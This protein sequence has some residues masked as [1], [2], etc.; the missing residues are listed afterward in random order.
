[1]QPGKIISFFTVTLFNF[2]LEYGGYCDNKLFL[3]K[4]NENVLLSLVE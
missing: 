2:P 4:R 1:M 3:K